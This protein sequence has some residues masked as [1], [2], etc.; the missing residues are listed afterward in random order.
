MLSFIPSFLRVLM[1]LQELRVPP[2]S[3][4]SRDL[5]A[6]WD[7][8][9]LKDPKVPQVQLAPR[10]NPVSKVHLELEVS[11]VSPDRLASRV[12]WDLPE[13]VV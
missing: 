7:S 4:V 8:R 12:R 5:W 9:V 2:V 13:S 11:Q 1:D 10:E 6:P 3:A